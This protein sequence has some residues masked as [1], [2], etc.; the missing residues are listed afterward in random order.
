MQWRSGM[1]YETQNSNITQFLI[2]AAGLIFASLGLFMITSIH[3]WQVF[4]AWLPLA[5]IA[6]GLILMSARTYSSLLGAFFMAVGG[7]I[8]LHEASLSNFPTLTSAIDWTFVVGG[9]LMVL[10][11]L[12]A[13]WRKR[14][15]RRIHI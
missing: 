4:S 6:I 13:I 1:D 11:S 10:L 14:Y 12:V 8:W 9:C 3:T 5:L 2:I 15:S 7:A